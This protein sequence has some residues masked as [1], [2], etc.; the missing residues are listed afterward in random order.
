MKKLIVILFLCAQLPAHQVVLTWTA[1]NP[2]D[3]NSDG[4]VNNTDLMLASNMAL[5][6]TPCTAIIETPITINGTLTKVCTVRT[7]ESIANYL[8]NGT[9]TTQSPPVTGYNIF[10]GTTPG[11]YPT[12]VNSTPITGT[13]FTDTTVQNGVTY[14]YVGTAV[15]ANGDQSVYS[16]SATAVIPAQ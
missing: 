7:V 9:C 2:C 5:N 11:L 12:Q 13:T 4:T 3:L 6:L 16:N 8:L 14:Y 10:R 1:S 15:D